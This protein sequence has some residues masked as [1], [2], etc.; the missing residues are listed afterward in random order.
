MADVDLELHALRRVL[1][2][3]FLWIL[4]AVLLHPRGDEFRIGGQSRLHLEIGIQIIPQS[5]D[6]SAEIFLDEFHL[7][8]LG[9]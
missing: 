6:E 9:K 4:L 7:A 3:L 8:G 5:G 1:F 2:V